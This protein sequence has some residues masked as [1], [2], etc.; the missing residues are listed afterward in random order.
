MTQPSLGRDDGFWFPK[1]YARS[2]SPPFD[3][4]LFKIASRC[5]LA[6][7]YCYVY[8]LPDQSWRAQPKFIAPA[9]HKKALQRVRE[10]VTSHSVPTVA[11]IFHGGEPLLIG[12]QRL[13]EIAARTHDALADI[14]QVYL[15]LQT[16]GTLLDDDFLKVAQRHQIRIGLSVDGPPYHHDRFRYYRNRRG[17][18]QAV[19]R[20]ATL[21]RD[22]PD[23]FGGI[24]CVVDLELDPSEL[25]DYVC[26][27][28]PPTIDLLL[29]HATHDR[30]PP[31]AASKSEILRYGDW[32]VRF[33]ELWYRAG[34]DR[35]DVRYFSSI[36]RRL[37]GRKSL[38]ESIGG[39]VITLVVIEANGDIEAVD[40]LK[41][42]FHG[43]TATGLNVFEHSLDAA[44]GASA[45]ASRHMGLASL[46][47]TCRECAFATVCGGGYLP[48]RYAS[49]QGFQNPSVY[50]DA[51][52]MVISRIATLMRDDLASIELSVPPEIASLASTAPRQHVG[53]RG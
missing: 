7:P 48:H 50:C 40:T 15:G 46:C 5:N 20:A 14:T 44:L 33:L 28:R 41:A 35:P 19:E 4:F 6:C 52:K 21:L 32:M 27:F 10:H 47:L 31:G 8:E 36:M 49:G 42:C 51:L 34:E 1:G 12:H 26:R 2:V 24:L 53:Q 22:N 30:L 16:N 39:G 18:S 45:I 17:S 3:T 9:T 43:A 25:W 11:A 23:V 13:D 29:P 38:V 37:M